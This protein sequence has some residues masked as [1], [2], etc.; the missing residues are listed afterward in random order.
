MKN[1]KNRQ[2]RKQYQCKKISI[3]GLLCAPGRYIIHKV[4]SIYKKSM[5]EEPNI[6]ENEV[7]NVEKKQNK[8]IDELRE[9]ARLRR[10][11]NRGKLS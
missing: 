5:K 11:K 1:S 4:E 10:I 3:F 7:S 2:K 6:L 9:I 8:S